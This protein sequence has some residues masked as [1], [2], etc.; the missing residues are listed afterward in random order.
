MSL[1]RIAVTVIA[2]M[3][4][5]LVVVYA[6]APIVVGA[7]ASVTAGDFLTFPPDGLSGRW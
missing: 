6:V 3:F 7:S 1:A 2:G 4:L 5:A